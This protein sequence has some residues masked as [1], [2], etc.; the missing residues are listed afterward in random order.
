MNQG[1]NYYILSGPDST[2][3]FVF[4]VKNDPQKHRGKPTDI[5]RTNHDSLYVAIISGG[6]D[7]RPGK[8]PGK[9]RKGATQLIQFVPPTGDNGFAKL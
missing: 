7:L 1:M 2:T 9:E 8:N 3:K 5:F 4:E 6:F